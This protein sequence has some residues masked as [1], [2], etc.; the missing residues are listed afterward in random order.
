MPCR[1]PCDLS[2]LLEYLGIV[3]V[4]RRQQGEWVGEGSRERRLESRNQDDGVP[5]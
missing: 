3:T 5:N 2:L 4:E 1:F